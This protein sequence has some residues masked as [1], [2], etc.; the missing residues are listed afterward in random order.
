MCL[1]RILVCIITSTRRRNRLLVLAFFGDARFGEAA[2]ASSSSPSASPDAVTM[3]RL[4]LR[5]AGDAAVAEGEAAW[6]VSLPVACLSI[7]IAGEAAAGA[8]AGAGVSLSR[9]CFSF[10]RSCFLRR[11]SVRFCSI[12]D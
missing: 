5:E 11:S 7:F 12:C 6:A 4:S 3:A 10:D 9:F 1:R 2:G 8:G